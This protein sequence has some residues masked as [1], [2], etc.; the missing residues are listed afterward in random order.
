MTNINKIKTIF[1]SNL[2]ISAFT[3]GGGYVIVPMM[4]KRFSDELK[5]VEEK[6]ISEM[7]ALA[8][9][10]PG[11]IAINSAILIGYRI[12]GVSGAISAILGAVLPPLATL[13]IIAFFYDQLKNNATISAIM[14]GLQISAAAVIIGAVYDICAKSLK[15]DK[16]FSAFIIVSA[17]IG[18]VI[19]RLNIVYIL[20]TAGILGFLKMTFSTNNKKDYTK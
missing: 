11:P 12:A 10:A 15:E 18:A 17:F 19:F 6:E 8:Q 2:F 7:I 3:F 16:I 14:Q 4:K 1:F 9:S 13:S 5:W 20:I